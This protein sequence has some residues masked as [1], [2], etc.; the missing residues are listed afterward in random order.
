VG[1]QVLIPGLEKSPGE[2]T[3]THSSILSWRIPWA[4]ENV[5][6]DIRNHWLSSPCGMFLYR[7]MNPCLSY[8]F[9]TFHFQSAAMLRKIFLSLNGNVPEH[10]S[11]IQPG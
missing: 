3:A 9:L 2:G 1:D 7:V 11:R 6:L 5:K 10:G 8:Y 4:E